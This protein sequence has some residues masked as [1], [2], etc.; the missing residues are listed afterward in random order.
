MSFRKAHE[1]VVLAIRVL[2]VSV[3]RKVQIC[4]TSWKYIY[5][6]LVS[7]HKV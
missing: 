6:R 7:S 5:S 1:S 4:K 3:F 2:Q